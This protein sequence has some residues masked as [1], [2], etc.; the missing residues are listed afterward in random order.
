MRCSLSSSLRRLYGP[1]AST[2]HD[3]RTFRISQGISYSR[4]VPFW[5]PNARHQPRRYRADREHTADPAGCKPMLAKSERHP[6]SRGAISELWV[7][8]LG[9]RVASIF[10]ET[11]RFPV[12]ADPARELDLVSG[13]NAL[14]L[15]SVFLGLEFLISISIRENK[16]KEGSNFIANHGYFLGRSQKS[17]CPV[18]PYGHQ[19][20]ILIKRPNPK[21]RV[22]CFRCWI[23][24]DHGQRHIE[25]IDRMS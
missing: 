1:S 4:V 7:V 17:T 25:N 3:D 23:P 21:P 5:A 10:R 11:G 12:F 15:D 14:V 9:N 8:S 20:R 19:P 24:L 2:R 18:L 22:P 16:D 6:A 13:Q